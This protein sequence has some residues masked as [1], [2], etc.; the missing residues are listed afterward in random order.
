MTLIWYNSGDGQANKNQRLIVRLFGTFT[1]SL[2]R[3][4]KM[5]WNTV[6]PTDKISRY[7]WENLGYLWLIGPRGAKVSIKYDPLFS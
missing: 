5:E 4:A 3:Q 1:S 2:Y 6:C 7:M